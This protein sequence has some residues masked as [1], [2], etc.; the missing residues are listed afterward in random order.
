MVKVKAHTRK[1][2]DGKTVRVR[3]H[4]RSKP[5]KKPAKIKRRSLSEWELS[6]VMGEFNSARRA[7]KSGENDLAVGLINEI[8]RNLSDEVEFDWEGLRKDR[9]QPERDA[10][11]QLS[12]VQELISMDSFEDALNRLDFV[13]EILR[14]NYEL[15][16]PL[17]HPDKGRGYREKLKRL[18]EFYG[19]T[20]YFH[21]PL[22]P[23]IN[24]TEGVKYLSDNIAAWL[25]SDILAVVWLDFKDEDFLVWELKVKGGKAELT[26]RKDEG[27][28]AVYTQEYGWTDLPDDT[29][30]EIW[31]ENGVLLLPSEH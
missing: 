13:E 26:A 17:I 27:K 30:I 7:I 6:E 2:K 11:M 8:K 18:G 29:E 23:D 21:N 25:V 28:P 24:Y 12:D 22:Y 14:G 10:F 16:F 1:T 15:D 3:A 9:K 31:Q 20:Q 5:D 4:T 19:T